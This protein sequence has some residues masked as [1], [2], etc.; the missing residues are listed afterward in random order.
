M[1]GR[2]EERKKRGREGGILLQL[3]TRGLIIQKVALNSEFI[4]CPYS[5]ISRGCAVVVAGLLAWPS[6]RYSNML[7]LLLFH[8][9]LRIGFRFLKV[10]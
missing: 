6:S 9:R 5:S 1:R 10:V 7:C 3:P 2:K 8:D 4:I